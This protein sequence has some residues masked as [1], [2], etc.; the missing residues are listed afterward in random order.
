MSLLIMGLNWQRVGCSSVWGGD[1]LGLVLGRAVVV[2]RQVGGFAP[3]RWGRLGLGFMLSGGRRV[4]V[5]L[6]HR[7]AQLTTDMALCELS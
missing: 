3:G 2:S 5:A 7:S 1:N 4:S 6:V